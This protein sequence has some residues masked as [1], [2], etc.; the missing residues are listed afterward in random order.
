MYIPSRGARRLRMRKFTSGHRVISG[1][2][3]SKGFNTRSLGCWTV[4]HLKKKTPSKKH[5]KTWENIHHLRNKKTQKTW[6]NIRQLRK[7]KHQ[8]SSENIHHIREKNIKRARKTSTI[9]GNKHLKIPWENIHHLRQKN[10]K[11][12]ENIHHL[13]KKTSKDLGKHPPSSEKTPKDLGK[14]NFRIFQPASN[15]P[16]DSAKLEPKFEGPYFDGFPGEVNYPPWVNMAQNWYTRHP[17]WSAPPR[18]RRLPLSK[19][20]Y[21]SKTRS[22]KEIKKSPSPVEGIEPQRFRCTCQAIRIECRN[23]P[24]RWSKG[25]QNLHIQRKQIKGWSKWTK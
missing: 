19:S 11:T 8:K 22:R 13:R 23:R 24:W 9:F 21:L 2:S 18:S 25:L 1:L 3:S 5:Q 17:M 15:A 7:K 4:G 6:E 16:F 12:W 10:Q 20:A 14:H